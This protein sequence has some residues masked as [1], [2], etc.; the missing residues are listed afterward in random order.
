MRKTLDWL[1]SSPKNG[2][3]LLVAT[4]SLYYISPFLIS[5]SDVPIDGV[6]RHGQFFSAKGNE[7]QKVFFESLE[8]TVKTLGAVG[9]NVVYMAPIPEMLVP[10]YRCA[11]NPKKNE[12]QTSRSLNQTYRDEFMRELRLLDERY[13]GLT[14][15][16]PFD[17][18]CQGSSCGNFYRG[19]ALY[20]DD[21]HL[22]LSM[23]ESLAEDLWGSLGK[24][25]NRSG[26]E[27]VGQTVNY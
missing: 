6:L 3:V 16:D 25:I 24:V 2:R 5:E 9:V 21:D 19:Q 23:A 7:A 20:R 8:N 18:I 4:R 13:P 14:V 1:K 10:T 22:T 11:F 15:W 26:H 17:K 27:S 12:C